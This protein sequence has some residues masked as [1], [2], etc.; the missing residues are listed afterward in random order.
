MPAIPNPIPLLALKFLG[1]MAAG[2]GLRRYLEVGP[3][4]IRFGLVRVVVGLGL[5]LVTL[6]VF[7]LPEFDKPIYTGLW[8][9]AVRLTVWS[10][11]IRH[12]FKRS[13]TSKR[14]F[15][16]LSLAGVGWPFLLDGV[17]ALLLYGFPDLMQIPFC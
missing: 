13:L 2:G 1:Y 3:N 9:V 11:L 8:L 17:Y 12:Y 7:A 4:P 16:L 10:L 14:Q 5:G 15:F 6:P